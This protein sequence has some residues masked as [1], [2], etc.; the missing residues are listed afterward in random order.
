MNNSVFVLSALLLLVLPRSEAIKC[1]R[2][3]TTA[4]LGDTDIRYD[5][6]SSNRASDQDPI[7]SKF[8]GL[9]RGEGQLRFNVLDPLGLPVSATPDPFVV[10]VPYVDFVNATFDSTGSRQI[11][12]SFWI[13]TTPPASLFFQRAF[14]FTTTQEKDGTLTSLP[15]IIAQGVNSSDPIQGF[16]GTGSQSRSYPVDENTIYITTPF[17]A[18]SNETGTHTSTRVCLDENCDQ[19][20]ES[21]NS[22]EMLPNGTV[23]RE[24]AYETLYT[25]VAS[26]Q[27]WR[28][29]I[30]AAY[31][32]NEIDESERVSPNEDLCSKEGF[33]PTEEEW[34]ESDPNCSISPYKE[35]AAHVKPGAIAGFAVAGIVLL[36]LVLYGVHR[37]LNAKQAQRYRTLFA[38]RIADTIQ[39]RGS[40]RSMNPGA[41]AAEFERIDTGVKDGKLSKEELWEFIST[42][43]AGDVD[44]RDFDALF[45]AIDLDKNGT[46]DFLEFCAFMGKCHDEYRVARVER[47]SIVATKSIRRE[48][49]GTT[50]RRLSSMA[51]SPAADIEDPDGV[52]EGKGGEK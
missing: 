6:K 23:F 15:N 8:R 42:G 2:P 50:A 40:V 9:F 26:A 39:V 24:A 46:V 12:H 16:S 51:P 33:C 22:F 20:H 52:E 10:S 5:P 18:N 44:K 41:L 3:L 25:R 35:P 29:G 32:E 34:C 14:F 1:G 48:L 19:Y 7:W 49:A 4:C 31:D 17:S 45:A 28:D 47:G 36:V 13:Q 21:S 37:Y 27:E 38:K 43:K 11:G 30:V